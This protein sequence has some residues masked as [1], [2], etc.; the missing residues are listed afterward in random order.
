MIDKKRCDS[1]S[2][3]CGRRIS[4]EDI[5]RAR[6]IQS[7]ECP[8]CYCTWWRWLTFAW[9]QSIQSGCNFLSS[10]KPPGW[11]YPE[12]ACKRVDKLSYV[13]QFEPHHGNLWSDDMAPHWLFGLP[14]IQSG[15]LS[16]PMQTSDRQSEAALYSHLT[17][18]DAEKCKQLLFHSCPRRYCAWWQSHDFDWETPVES[19]CQYPASE[20]G[21][22][23]C[24]RAAP[25]STNDDHFQIR[26]DRAIAD[27][28]LPRWYA[29][30]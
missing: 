23:P 13:D 22:P 7:G 17:P 10:G 5:A 27:G 19:G 12:S 4:L 1:D 15:E 8:R 24:R 11:P 20:L 29:K 6:A 2:P 25:A 14:I 26:E 18:D 3:D 16:P 28:L 9:D 30:C 21:V